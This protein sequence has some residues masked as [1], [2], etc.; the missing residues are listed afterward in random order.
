MNSLN[1]IVPSTAGMLAGKAESLASSGV[2]SVETAKEIAHQFESIFASILLKEMRQSVGEEGLFGGDNADVYGGMFD[3]YLGQHIAKAG[4]FGVADM[5]TT[6][7]EM[8]RE[9]AKIHDAK[10]A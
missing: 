7:L 9:Q 2:P 4:N 8:Y 5:V 1:T 6:Q 3:L 10:Q